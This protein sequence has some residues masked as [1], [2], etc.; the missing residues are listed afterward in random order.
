MQIQTK[1]FGELEIEDRTVI[2]FDGGLSVAH[3]AERWVL[4]ATSERAP[5]AFLQSIDDPD[6]WLLVTEPRTFCAAF[7]PEFGGEIEQL[8]G[9]DADRAGLLSLAVVTVRRRRLVANLAQPILINVE[10]PGGG[11]GRPG[12]RHRP[13]G[14]VG[15]CDAAGPVAHRRR[16]G[17]GGGRGL[18]ATV[19]G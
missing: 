1:H 13:V 19:K 12:H 7:N 6:Q 17:G 14:G 8:L 16:G 2:T 10:R 5:F 4:L 9:L 18:N 15:R 3:P 11:G